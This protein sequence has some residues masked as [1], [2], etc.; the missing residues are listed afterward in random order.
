MRRIIVD[1]ARHEG[2]S[3]RGG[4]AARI[5]IDDADPAAPAA[6]VDPADAFVLDQALTR[7]EALDPQ[8]G[9]IVELRYF[10]GLTIE[11][12]AAVMQLST[13]TVKRDWAVARAWL[14]REMTGETS[15]F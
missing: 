12:T 6:A 4:G 14:Y 1:H 10:G 15:V 13:G 2:R 9:R 3:K 11:E 7:L 5:S 8:Q